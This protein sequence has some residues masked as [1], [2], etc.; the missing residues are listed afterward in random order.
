MMLIAVLL[1]KLLY[2]TI[3]WKTERIGYITGVKSYNTN[4]KLTV[5]WIDDIPELIITDSNYADNQDFLL[6]VI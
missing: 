1:W 2:C 3:D 6:I 5:K 4:G